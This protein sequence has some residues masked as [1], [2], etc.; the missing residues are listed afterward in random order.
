MALYQDELLAVDA[1]GLVSLVF[2]LRRGNGLPLKAQ[3]IPLAWTSCFAGLLIYSFGA[4]APG[5]AHYFAGL[6]TGSALLFAVLTWWLKKQRAISV[7]SRQGVFFFAAF[8][9]LANTHYPV[10]QNYNQALWL[11]LEF[12]RYFVGEALIGLGLLGL[13]AINRWWLPKIGSLWLDVI[14]LLLI[15]LALVDLRITALLGV[16]F[17]WSVLALGNTPTM[18]WRMAKPYLPLVLLSLAA[19]AAVYIL[20]VRLL[21]RWLN[22]QVAAGSFGLKGRGWGY[23]AAVFAA[24]ALCGLHSAFPDKARGQAGIRLAATS[25]WWKRISG[26]TPSPEKFF[27]TAKSL[28]VT[29]DATAS[30]P[31]SLPPRELNV[32]LVFMES[33]YNQHLSLFG[34]DEETQP[35]LGRYKDRMELFPNFF[36]CFASSIHARFAA[37]TSLYP[38]QEYNTF[39]VER[40]PVKSIFDVLHDQ[41]YDCSMFYSSFADFTGFRDFLKGRGVGLYDADNMP[42]QRTTP[43]VSWGL[44][45]EE[46]L[47]AMR[48][49]IQKHAADGRKFFLTYVPAAPHYPYEGVPVR[50]RKFKMTEPGDYKAP[51]LN[52]LLY[53]DWVLASLVDQLRDSGLLEKTLVVI[54]DD[55]GE[56]LGGKDGPIGHGW[57]LTPQL[58]NA[59]LIILDPEKP[60][61]HVN[62]TVGSQVDL[63]P[64]L[65]DRLRIPFPADQLYQGRSLDAAGDGPHRLIYLNSFQQYAVLEGNRMLFGDREKEHGSTGF[66]TAYAITNEGTKTI[67]TC[68]TGAAA[69]PIS[70]RRFDEFQQALLKNYST[71]SRAAAQTRGRSEAWSATP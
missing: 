45:E 64:T 49:E 52:E 15:A 47:G 2:A 43:R 67:F 27:E 50:F 41:G 6:V 8:V 10:A 14:S 11:G 3:V 61:Y 29:F 59:P 65:C 60:G 23:A 48:S 46:T 1:I 32:V 25:P 51:Y 58:V 21:D 38:V 24:L 28:G 42:G 4:A 5:S 56:M 39:T 63:L 33:T 68:E 7:W 36:S 18:M 53:M 71:Y 70:I 40:V 17:D 62:P 16:R 35:L 37:F 55:H 13:A 20:T 9:L 12:P 30:Y 69:L 57:W 22:R 19:L 66:G 26:H 34:A 31:K 44:R 54:T